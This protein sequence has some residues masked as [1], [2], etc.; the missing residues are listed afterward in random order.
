MQLNANHL[1][2]RISGGQQHSPAHAGAEID[3]RVCVDR[4]ERAALAPAHDDSLKDGWRDCVVGR[5]VAVVAVAGAEMAACN[6]A[7]GAHAK[8]EVEGVA[9]Q[10]IFFGQPGQDASAGGGLL[11]FQLAWRANAHA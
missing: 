3:K 11:R 1:A 6:E 9:D 7:A 10:A 4:R 2:K 5:Y 8:F